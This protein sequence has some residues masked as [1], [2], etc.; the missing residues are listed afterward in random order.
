MQ[1]VVVI[2][3]IKKIGVQMLPYQFGKVFLQMKKAE[4]QAFILEEI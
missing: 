4:L 1:R 3:Q 2:G